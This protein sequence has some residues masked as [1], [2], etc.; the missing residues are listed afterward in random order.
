[1]LWT[2]YSCSFRSMLKS[3]ASTQN[4]PMTCHYQ[5]VLTIDSHFHLEVGTNFKGVNQHILVLE[6]S[7]SKFLNSIK[8]CQ[9]AHCLHLYNKSWAS[10]LAD[11]FDKGTGVLYSSL[12]V[13]LH[14]GVYT[15]SLPPSMGVKSILLCMRRTE[16]LTESKICEYC[17]PPPPPPPRPP[18]PL[19]LSILLTAPYPHL[20]RLQGPQCII[21]SALLSINS[22]CLHTQYKTML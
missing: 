18:P 14:D 16:V 5:C 12:F 8:R 15:P 1:M 10:R 22:D 7:I 20:P 17:H 11:S 6:A 4:G 9:S 21:S 3:S 13:P 19:F 2:T